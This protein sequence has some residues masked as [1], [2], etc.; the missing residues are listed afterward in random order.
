MK[1][2]DFYLIILVLSAA[3]IWYLFNSHDFNGDRGKGARVHI[4]S[5]S[6]ETAVLPLDRDTSLTVNGYGGY[7]CLVN[8]T[9]G[10]VNVTEATCPDKLCV[11]QKSISKNGETIVCLPARIVIEIETSAE[12][13][14]SDYDGIS[15]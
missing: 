10:R 13:G 2:W 1:R 7:T 6:V 9:S 14:L 11:R 15:E 12:R 5:D 4:Y 8:I 3:G